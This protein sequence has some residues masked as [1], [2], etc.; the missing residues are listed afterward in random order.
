[1]IFEATNPAKMPLATSSRKLSCKSLAGI[2]VGTYFICRHNSEAFN[3]VKLKILAL[4]KII[5]T[6]PEYHLVLW[7]PSRL[8]QP[9][10]FADQAQLDRF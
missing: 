5:K 3:M 6:G 2:P 4:L 1:M 9:A 10:L 8:P 7:G